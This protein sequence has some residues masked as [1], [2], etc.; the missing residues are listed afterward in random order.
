VKRDGEA[1]SKPPF[2][3]NS[4]SEQYESPVEIDRNEEQDPLCSADQLGA[5]GTDLP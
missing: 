5:S 2:V 1:G 4:Y 3:L